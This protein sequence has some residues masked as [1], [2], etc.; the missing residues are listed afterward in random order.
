[1]AGS[2]RISAAM[3]VAVTI[4]LA[5]CSTPEGESQSPA[6]SPAVQQFDLSKLSQLESAMPEGFVPFP[7]NVS[8]LP[9]SYAAGVGTALPGSERVE[10][11]PAHC[12]PLL[13]PVDG[14]SGSESARLRADAPDK[15]SIA[16]AADTPVDVRLNF[17]IS[18]CEQMTYT[19][20]D[21]PVP[22]RG[23]VE[24]IGAPTIDGAQ[25][26]AL[27][28]TVDGFPDPEYFY[29]AIVDDRLFFDINARVA[30]DFPAQQ[31]LSELLVRAVEAVTG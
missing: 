19:V 17:P 25:T 11:E 14:I 5:G 30:P 31:E 8:T 15:R 10:V 24:R 18:G 3:A 16:I 29:A 13:K 22:Y 6:P 27:K 12:A 28:I 26:Y 4:G 9:D 1:M 23:T 21:A 7:T 2:G 20:P